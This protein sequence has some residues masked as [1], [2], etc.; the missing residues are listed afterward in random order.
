MWGTMLLW[1][2]NVYLIKS[3]VY[4]KGSREYTMSAVKPNAII[5]TLTVRN[6]D[7]Q[8]VPPNTQ[9]DPSQGPNY[10]ICYNTF[11]WLRR[12]ETNAT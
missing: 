2:T 6:I 3:S 12:R 1:M 9:F 7:F 8:N 5:H 11:E 10:S 4:A